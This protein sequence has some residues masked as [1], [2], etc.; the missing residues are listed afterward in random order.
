MT[1]WYTQEAIDFIDKHIYENEK[2]NTS[3]PFFLYWTPDSLHAT[4]FRSKNYV[5]KSLKFSSYGDALMEIDDGIGKILNKI[6]STPSIS[7][8][9]F[10]FFTSDNGAALVSKGDA[11][12]SGP[13]LCGKQT[14]F[15][16][17]I[18]E[19]GIAWWNTKI[20]PGIT[21]QSATIMDLF[22]TIANLTG[23][24]NYEIIIIIIL[25]L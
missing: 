23:N 10:V 6:K 7:T 9:T 25:F 5:N 19:P 4:T 17:G 21:Q 11:G 15:E 16:G 13:F 18:R 14:T 1:Q 2:N 20:K 3:K 22:A 24:Y 12:S 8:N